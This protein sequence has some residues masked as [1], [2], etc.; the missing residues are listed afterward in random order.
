VVNLTRFEITGGLKE[1]DIV[2][3]GATTDVD[4]TNGLQVKAQ[5]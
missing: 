1:G 5:P 4:L 2:A 3:L